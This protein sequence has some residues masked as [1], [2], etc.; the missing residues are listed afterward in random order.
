VKPV[1]HALLNIVAAMLYQGKYDENSDKAHEKTAAFKKYNLAFKA[2]P[3]KGQVRKISERP[4]L[5][6]VCQPLLG[7]G[8]ERKPQDQDRLQFQARRPLC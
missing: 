6:V 2:A 7:A 4:T 3:A 5:F 1:S 8:R